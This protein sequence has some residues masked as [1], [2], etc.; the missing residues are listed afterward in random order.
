M[1]RLAES[2]LISL[3]AQVTADKTSYKKFIVENTYLAGEN[4]SFV[5]HEFQEYILDV[6]ESNPGKTFSVSKPSQIGLSELFNRLIIAIAAIKA[7]TGILVS[8]PSI[9]FSQ[10]VFRTR[11]APIIN[12]SPVLRSLIDKNNDS[13]SVKRFHNESIMYALGG[14]L[15]SKSSLLNRPISLV[16]CDE[17][18]RQDIDI[19]SGYSTRMVHTKEKDRL[20]LNVSTPTVD[21]FGINA[22]IKQAYELHTPW[23]KCPCGHE[24]VPDYYENVVIPGYKDSLTL[25]TRE[26]ASNLDLDASYLECPE[27]KGEINRGNYEVVWKI[28]YNEKGSKNEIAIEMNPFAAMG[29]R[30]IPAI[31]KDSINMSSINEFTNQVLGKV[32][33]RS[34]TTISLSSLTFTHKEEETGHN[35]FG[36]DLGKECHWL[37]G[38]QKGDTT[39]HIEEAQIIKLMDLEE[40][41][42]EQHQKFVFAA[43]VVDSQPYTDLVYRLIKKYP[44]LFSAIYVSPNPPKPWMY[45]LKNFDRMNEIVR[46]I[47]INKGMAMDSFAGSLKDFFTFESSPMDAT[48]SKHFTSMR[49][50]RD[51]RFDEMI[52]KWEKSSKGDDHFWHSGVYLFMAGKLA[53][54]G[55]NTAYAV[56]VTIGKMNVD[57]RRAELRRRTF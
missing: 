15:Q 4:F 42:T 20:V 29:F 11:L 23:I 19:M 18:D 55:V 56:P 26:K 46:Q 13:S 30:S 52:Y 44:R 1:K 54:A 49:R 9:T 10:E 12:S 24:F 33:D 36:L 57:H 21:G 32:A 37:R 7:G 35:I 31:V 16:F 14:S 51:Y 53:Y 40:F 27:C 38:K 6:I 48:I 41:L 45:E 28:S 8:F 17:T 50:V 22:L 25:L 47:T 43:G 5:D 34:S 3:K 39:T 2:F